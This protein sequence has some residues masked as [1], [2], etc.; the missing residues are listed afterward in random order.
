[1]W[2]H[3]GLDHYI[4]LLVGFLIPDSSFHIFGAS[5]GSTSFVQSF[6][7]EALH[8]NLGTIFSLPVL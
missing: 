7:V 2:S 8:E 1:M 5:I 3:E 6:V 4:S